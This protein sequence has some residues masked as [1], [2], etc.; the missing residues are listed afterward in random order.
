V[1]LAGVLAGV[2]TLCVGSTAAATAATS[3]FRDDW[4]VAPGFGLEVSSS[5]FDLPTA[6]AFVPRPGPGPKSPLYF[7]TELRGR[8]KV[9]T[10]D[11]TV[12]TFADLRLPGPPDDYPA[13]VAQNGSA[14]ICLDDA[15]GYVFVTYAAFEGGGVLRNGMVRL[16][17]VP[18]T[19]GLASTGKREIGRIF[20]PWPTSANH[21]IGGCVVKDGAVFVGVGDGTVATRA[22]D[23]DMLSGKIVRM[24]VDGG[25]APGNPFCGQSGPRR[26]GWAYGLRNPF[27]LA[28]VGD[29]LYATQNGIALDSFLRI[30]RGR[31]YGWN[32]T[33]PSIE[34]NAEAIMNPSVAPVHVAYVPRGGP[35]PDAA[36]SAF[37]FA[38]DQTAGERGAGVLTLPYDVAQHRVVSPPTAFVRYRGARGG[39]V[40]ALALGPDGVYFAPILPGRTGVSSV[41]RIVPDLDHTYPHPLATTQ[42]GPQLFAQYGCGGCHT[43][44]GIGTSVG[45]PLDRDTLRAHV[46]ERLSSD[47]YRAQVER[48]D[49]LRRPPFPDWRDERHAILG[50]TGDERLLRWVTARIQEPIFDDP[51]ASMPRLG[52]DA[53]QAQAVATYLL[54]GGAAGEEGLAGPAAPSFADR[55]RNTLSSKKFGAGVAAG[56]VVALFCLALALLGRRVARS[57]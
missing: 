38:S 36:A 46:E 15:H 33:D 26:Y 8:V 4:A 48:V 5:G 21:Q 10:R 28:A 18:G 11:G 23:P 42:T 45:P 44:G 1:R 37:Y 17:S 2:A 6:I 19:F 56:L 57:S 24:T 54:E 27:G 32:G 12:Q 13:L 52:L 39:E 25:P 53:G 20:A 7:V 40:A 22:Q 51:N 47:E 14:G 16:T 49:A 31:N 41:Y 50:A 34:T 9:V 3:D 35:F 30:E 29:E 55:A 43:I